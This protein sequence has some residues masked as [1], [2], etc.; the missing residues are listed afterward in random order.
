MNCAEELIG[1][2]LAIATAA[3][4]LWHR[5]VPTLTLVAGALCLLSTPPI[6]SSKLDR[7][8][9]E[10]AQ[11]PTGASVRAMIQA[12]P[13]AGA[14]V[15]DRL[16]TLAI[17]RVTPSTTPDLLVAELS[18]SALG[19]VARDSNVAHLSLDAMVKSFGSAL[20]QDTLLATEGLLTLNGNSWVLATPYT[21]HNIGVAVID[22]GVTSGDGDLGPITFYDVTNQMKQGG[23][24]DDYGHGTHVSGLIASNGSFS[25]YQYQAIASS[26]QLIEMK[27]LDQNGNGYTSDVINAINF[28][29]QNQS[30]LHL[31][32]INLSLGH[33]IYEPAASDPLVQAVENAIAAGIVVVVSAGNFGG[34]LTTHVPEYAGITSPGNAP[35]A[36]TV[37]ALDTQQ[38]V[39]R[40]DDVV[41]WYS[42]RGPTWYDG[43][44]KPDLVAPG[45]HLVSDVSTTSS[46][47]QDYPGGV[48]WV[49]G[50]PFLML[51]GTS[52]SA[53]VVSGVV[54]AMLDA[55]QT[56]HH[57][58]LLP[59]N[60]VKAILQYTAFPMA[61]YDTLT[62][63]A[64]ALNAAGAV[65]LAAV[66]DPNQPVGASWLATGVNTWTT[67]AGQTLAWGQRVVWGDRV[68]W[69]NQIL[70]ND[71]AWALRVVWGDRVIWGDRVVWGDSTVWDAGNPGI[72]GSRVIWGDSLIGQTDGTSV[73]WG[74]LSGDVTAAR[75]VWGDVSSLNIAPMSIS[76]SNLERAN[77]DLVAK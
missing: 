8:L 25:N 5:M 3:M 62:Q 27:V 36:I 43:F 61:G 64:G 35:D 16:K 74:S 31:G 38:T 66:I 20:G 49:G 41:A 22:S 67:I 73:T 46:L 59:P 37:G 56:N 60:A 45:T 11:H 17:G 69:G 30:R 57:G 2:L 21:G 15:S 72:W 12:R 48:V 39:S 28:V 77:G 50:K 71:P 34:D 54:A 76:W 32:V 9:R 29:V 4:T 24:Y 68:I 23:Q 70:S 6:A 7:A 33:P 65:A 53:G 75:V 40:S 63:G 13:G 19:V 51:S 1:A 58:A 52:M 42:S 14:R 18:P 10:W 55:S 44:Q 47:Y 26:A